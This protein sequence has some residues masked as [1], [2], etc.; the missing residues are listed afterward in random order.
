MSW[1]SVCMGLR[2]DRPNGSSSA[3]PSP[4]LAVKLE[5]ARN[6]LPDV[7]TLLLSNI[8]SKL[9]VTDRTQAVLRAREAGPG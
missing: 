5:T 2:S 7:R 8:F 4:G 9:Q 1:F 6:G 3:T